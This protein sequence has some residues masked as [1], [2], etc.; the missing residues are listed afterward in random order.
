MP[1]FDAQAADIRVLPAHPC[2]YPIAL[3]TNL[4][5]DAVGG[6]NAGA[7]V[8]VGR[9]FSVAADFAYA[10]W[11]INNTYALQ[12]TQGSVEGRYWFMPG[13]MPLTG[14]NS[15]VY[16]TYGGDYDVQFRGGYQGDGF[17]SAGVTGGYSKSLSHRFIIDFSLGAGYFFTFEVRHYS[18]PQDGRLVWDETRY[19]VGRFSLTKARVTLMWLF[20]MKRKATAR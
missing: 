5:F 12:T 16:A 17:W 20:D 3:R 1:H 11:R 19:N 14:W 2:L 13:A 8:P 10:H 6:L 18:A 15:G 9:R 4:L 7:E